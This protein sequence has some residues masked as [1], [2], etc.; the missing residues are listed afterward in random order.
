MR[1]AKAIGSVMVLLV[2]AFGFGMMAEKKQ[3]FSA[4][5]REVKKHISSGIGDQDVTRSR[6]WLEKSSF[7]STFSVSAP[8]VMIGDSITDGAEWSEMFPAVRIVNRGIGGD[9]VGGVLKRMESIY[10]IHAEKAFIMIGI[11]DIVVGKD[12]DAIF[13]DYKDLVVRLEKRGM[14]VFIQSTTMCNETKF[15]FGDCKEMNKATV[16]L[17]DKLARLQSDKIVFVNVNRALT[18]HNGLREE[19]TFDGLHLNGKGYLVWR[20]EIADY[21]LAQ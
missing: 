2:I 19:F 14:K 7:F 5:I 21:V 15:R 12:V 8:V 1:N 13:N 11:N 3:V 17:N 10:A 18:D 9:T 6:Y 16:A 4:Y 20:N